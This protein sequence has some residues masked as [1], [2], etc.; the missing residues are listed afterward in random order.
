MPGKHITQIERGKIELMCM[1]KMS[2]ADM[3]AALGRSESAIS[4]ELRRCPR[5]QAYC[6]QTAH[7]HYLSRRA[8]CGRKPALS[9]PQLAAYVHDKLSDALSP[10]QVA[11]RIKEDC[12]FNHRM[13]ISHETIYRTIYNDPKWHCCNDLLR[14]KHKVRRKRDGKYKRRGPIPNRVGIEERPAEVDS[15][16]VDGHWEGDAIIGANQKG[17]IVTLNERKNDL[18]RAVL[19][20]SKNSKDVA[21]AILQALD[22]IPEHLLKTITFDNGPEFAAHQLVSAQR[23]VD[24]YFADPYSPWQRARNENMNGLIREYFPKKMSFENLSQQE[25]ESV[26]NALN[27]RPRKKHGFRTPNEVWQEVLACT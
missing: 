8:A 6:A 19:V 22:D 12:P 17:A 15:L 25:V 4:R 18:L 21:K 13:R 7:R 2:Q 10:E 27:N 20:P 14:R 5:G 11:G 23:N 24:T 16:Q 1:H 9:D 3:A 26:V